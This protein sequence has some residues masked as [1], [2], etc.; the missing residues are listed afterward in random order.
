MKR[1]ATLII[2]SITILSIFYTHKA[3]CKG[4]LPYAIN[5]QLPRTN[6]DIPSYYKGYKISLK[7]GRAL[8]PES[9]APLVFS[10]VITP[11][12]SFSMRDRTVSSLIRSQDT[13][14]SWYDITLVFKDSPTE[15]GDEDASREYSWIIEKKS[16]ADIPKRL[17]LHALIILMDP[18]FIE[19]VIDKEVTHTPDIINLPTVVFKD[20]STPQQIEAFEN[21]LIIAAM[22]GLDLD[23]IHCKERPA[24]FANASAI[25]SIL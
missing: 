5:L 9:T 6:I 11:H 23:A 3:S 14:C 1:F 15:E 22:N 8:L 25:T 13:P 10:I 18:Q 12:V 4:F 17:P 20:L 7:E 16:L 21:A 24:C 2:C 19:T